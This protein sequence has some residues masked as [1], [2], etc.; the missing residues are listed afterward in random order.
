MTFVEF[1]CEMWCF[2]FLFPFEQTVFVGEDKAAGW[3]GAAASVGPGVPSVIR[4]RRRRAA[5]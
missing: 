4:K 5:G 1:Y 2:L 3:G